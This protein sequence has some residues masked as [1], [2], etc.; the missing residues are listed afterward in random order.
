VTANL[1]LRGLF[2]STWRYYEITI[3]REMIDS[4]DDFLGPE[5]PCA[6]FHDARLISVEIN[7][8]RRELASEWELCVGDPESPELAARERTRRGRLLCSG[9]CFWVV[10]PHDPILDGSMP[11]VTSDGPL[12]EAGTDLAKQLCARVPPGASAW[13]LYFPHRNAFAYCCAERGAV[14]WIE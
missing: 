9:L 10:E 8:E 13:Y 2:V 12:L 6:T 14:T 11:W 3:G 4:I 7:Y 5:E 1:F